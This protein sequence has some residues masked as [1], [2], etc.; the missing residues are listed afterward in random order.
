M[1]GYSIRPEYSVEELAEMLAELEHH[2][3][4]QALERADEI[5]ATHY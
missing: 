4:R 1:Y 3:R 5:A 2:E